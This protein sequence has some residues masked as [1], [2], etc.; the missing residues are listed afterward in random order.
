[1]IDQSA[2]G[3]DQNIDAARQRLGLGADAHAADDRRDA[4]MR[5]AAI[6]A[7]T[8]GDLRHKLTG[9]RQDKGAHPTRQHLPF[10]LDEAV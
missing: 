1:M 9:R 4:E 7:K 8:I 5:E 6:S 3:R 2:G 10:V